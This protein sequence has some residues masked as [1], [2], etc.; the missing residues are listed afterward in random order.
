M[1]ARNKIA[2]NENIYSHSIIE[3]TIMFPM[4]TMINIW[5]AARKE[6]EMAKGQKRSNKET[7]KPR[8]AQ[9]KT[10]HGGKVNAPIVT[11][12]DPR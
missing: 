2:A 4:L 10:V 9:P 11:L 7:R 1:P 3:I 5:T 12:K 8:A 6:R